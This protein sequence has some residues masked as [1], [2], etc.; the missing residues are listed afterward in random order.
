MRLTKRNLPL[1][2]LRAFEAVGRHLSMRRAAEELSV[3]H[4]AISQQ[5][6][7]LESLLE[8]SLLERTNKGLRLTT[9]GSHFLQEV[10]LAMD[11]LAEATAGLH[12]DSNK[13]QLTIASAPGFAANWLVPFLGDF[14]RHFSSFDVQILPLKPGARIPDEAELAIAYGKPAVPA[15]QVSR[16]LGQN[17]FPVA[18]PKIF[19]KS[20]IIRHPADLYDYNLL[21]EDE[22]ATWA[23]WFK[24][25][26]VRS[27]R[28]TRGLH[29]YG[30]SHLALIAAR[31]GLGIALADS[32]EVDSD[33]REGHLVRLFDQTIPGHSS[34]YLYTALESS[35][36]AAGR[37]FENWLKGSVK[38]LAGIG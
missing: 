24:A 18:N 15:A 33:L 4:S 10:G 19:H 14:L 37:M 3:S 2:A 32:M 9:A 38:D 28:E 35:R 21:H 5:I 34:Y 30:G 6:A 12:A 11:R 22:G 36:T 8:M 16:F 23:Q 27:G 29:L 1:N 26:G 17:L 7:K 20:Q 31:Q 25:A 13:G